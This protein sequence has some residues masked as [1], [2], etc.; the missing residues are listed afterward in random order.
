MTYHAFR[1]NYGH[2]IDALTEGENCIETGTEEW[3]D[4]LCEIWDG[5]DPYTE[6]PTSEE[7]N[8]V[9][10]LTQYLEENNIEVI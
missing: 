6:E 4:L 8:R 1:S 10:F 9:A 7:G 3:M 2:L 5:K